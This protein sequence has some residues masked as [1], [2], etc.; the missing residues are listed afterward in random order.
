MYFDTHAHID[1]R[2]YNETRYSVIKG[3]RGGGVS[4]IVNIGSDIESSKKSI[5]LAEKN[6]FIYAA[7]GVHPHEA[8]NLTAEDLMVLEKLADHPKVKAIGEI[9][10]DYHY[11][12][13]DRASQAFV[14]SKQMEIAKKLNMPV[15]I[16]CRDAIKDTLDILRQYD[17]MRG[18]MHSFSGSV[19]TAEILLDMGYY[20]S[21]NGIITFKNAHRAREAVA[22]V[23]RDRLLIETDC[24]YLTPEPF[25]GQVNTPNMVAYVAAAVAE[26]WGVSPEE[27]A[28]VTLENGKR[29]YGID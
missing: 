27:V 7:V 22:R 29:I 14:F 3:A 10:L 4:F 8:Q 11:D 1:D 15:V 6:D 13:S 18:I 9:G 24:P 26:I 23:P 28:A 2:R 20:L 12:F 17:G 25:R 19:E 5:S 16:H 21:F